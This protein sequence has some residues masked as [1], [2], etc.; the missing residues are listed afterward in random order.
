[1]LNRR[2][3]LTCHQAKRSCHREKKN[4]LMARHELTPRLTRFARG[5]ALRLPLALF[6]HSNFFPPS[7]G[8]CSQANGTCKLGIPPRQNYFFLLPCSLLR[9]RF[10]WVALRD[11][12]KNGCE[13][14]CF[15]SCGFLVHCYQTSLLTTLLP[16][17]ART[18]FES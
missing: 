11:N 12:P 14:D 6:A 7:L 17:N 4:L 8:A 16:E 1:M 3:R 15:V 9:S 10:F 5:F 2:R 18:A 13:G